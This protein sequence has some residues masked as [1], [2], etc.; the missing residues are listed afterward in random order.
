MASQ[1]RKANGELDGAARLFEEVLQ[2]YEAVKGIDAVETREAV[3]CLAQVHLPTPP[4]LQIRA[5]CSR[6]VY[7]RSCLTATLYRSAWRA[8][9]KQRAAR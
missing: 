6:C 7:M 5:V 2:K 1:A 4:H 8:K 9:Y 3:T